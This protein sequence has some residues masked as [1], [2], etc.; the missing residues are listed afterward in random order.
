MASSLEEKRLCLLR[1]QRD[2]HDN[3][4]RTATIM[5]GQKEEEEDDDDNNNN[6]NNDDESHGAMADLDNQEM[7]SL[8]AESCQRTQDSLQI[9]KRHLLETAHHVEQCSKRL[10]SSL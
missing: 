9:R 4:N 2:D 10:R 3:I 7:L 1:I 5:N 8:Y 6:N